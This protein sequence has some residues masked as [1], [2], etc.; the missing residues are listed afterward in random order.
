MVR[1]LANLQ[2]GDGFWHNLLDKNDT[3]TET[4]CTAMFT[5]AIAKGI[6]EGW[7]SHVYTS[8]TYRLECYTNTSS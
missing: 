2:G 7:I 5:F 8:S 1:S 6:N 3:Y 4:S